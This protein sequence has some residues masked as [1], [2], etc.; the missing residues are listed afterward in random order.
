MAGETLQLCKQAFL[1][2]SNNVEAS[3]SA[4][5]NSE[6]FKSFV[7][8]WWEGVSFG[9]PAYECILRKILWPDEFKYKPLPQSKDPN[10]TKE[11][12]ILKRYIS[13]LGGIPSSEVYSKSW[14]KPL[15]DTAEIPPVKFLDNS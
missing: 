10:Q 2:Y 8:S 3:L 15:K 12:P 14:I 9:Q 4:L 7:V 11:V 1:H 13:R 6:P 5:E